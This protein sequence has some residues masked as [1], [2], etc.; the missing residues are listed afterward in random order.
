M[1]RNQFLTVLEVRTSKIKVLT[2]MVCTEGSWFT[3]GDFSL[4]P[5]MV[6]GANK[7]SWA[8]LGANPAYEVSA[9]MIYSPPAM[10]WTYLPSFVCWK[11]NCHCNNI[12][13]WGLKRWLDHEGTTLMNGWRLLLREW[14]SYKRREFNPISSLYILALLSPS[15]FPPWDD[16]QQM[17]VP[18]LGLSSF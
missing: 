3:H 12:N 18:C 9:F 10:G 5:H 4:H 7:L 14:V 2:D 1:N 17:P 11:F 6:E 15:N 8:S 13:K 16:P